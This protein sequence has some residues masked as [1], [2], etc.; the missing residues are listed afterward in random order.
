MRTVKQ[1]RWSWVVIR[2]L[3]AWSGKLS[4][5]GFTRNM[6]GSSVVNS[7]F[8]LSWLSAMQDWPEASREWAHGRK[9]KKMLL[10]WCH[11]ILGILKEFNSINYKL[12]AKPW[13]PELL[14]EY[15][16]AFCLEIVKPSH[17]VLPFLVL[18]LNHQFVAIKMCLLYVVQQASELHILCCQHC[19]TNMK[20]PPET[21]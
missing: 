5:R 16:D 12:M 4:A 11:E 10:I 6:I 2:L 14:L 8:F 18:Q 7:I 9:E 15:F 21:G 13:K 17:N 19:T 1:E 3:F 20:L